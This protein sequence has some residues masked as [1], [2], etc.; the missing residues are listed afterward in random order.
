MLALQQAALGGWRGRGPGRQLQPLHDP[1]SLPARPPGPA[2]P[3]PRPSKAPAPPRRPVK[4]RRPSA[5]PPTCAPRAAPPPPPRPQQQAPQVKVDLNAPPRATTDS[6]PCGPAG[7]VGRTVLIW[8]YEFEED[9]RPEL[10]EAGAMWEGKIVGFDAATG[11]HTVG[12]AACGCGRRVRAGAGSGRGA[13]AGGKRPLL[14]AQKGARRASC[15]P[16]PGQPAPAPE[17][18]RASRAPRLH[19]TSGAGPRQVACACSWTTLAR[20]S[21][22]R[23]C[24]ARSTSSGTVGEESFPFLVML[25]KAKLAAN[26]SRVPVAGWA[27]ACTLVGAGWCVMGAPAVRLARRRLTLGGRKTSRR[28]GLPTSPSS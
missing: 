2:P 1:G 15:A 22:W 10:G 13:G 3:C 6:M 27:G 5:A 9:E 11:K 21:T 19:R 23:L 14:S 8:F 18:L 16:R 4:G 7:A 28:P 17:R 24:W 25:G 26:Y 12:R 20:T